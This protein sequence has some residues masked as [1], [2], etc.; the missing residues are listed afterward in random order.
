METTELW[1]SMKPRCDSGTGCVGANA[2][3][4]RGGVQNYPV[5]SI[6]LL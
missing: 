4:R 5:R 1:G 2:T 6:S 3:A